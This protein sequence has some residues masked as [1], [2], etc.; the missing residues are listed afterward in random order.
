MF[1]NWLKRRV[2][3]ASVRSATQDLERF[4]ASLRGM[5]DLELATLVVIATAVR[6]SLRMNGQAP[7]EAYGLTNFPP[8][9]QATVQLTVST[10]VRKFQTTER[11]AYASGAMV[12]LHTLRAG[13]MPELSLL[14]RQMWGELSR[15]FPHVAE[16]IED[17]VASTGNA[18]PPEVAQ[19]S[20]FVPPG[21]EPAERKSGADELSAMATAAMTD[22]KAKWIQFNS[23]IHLKAGI[24]LAVKMESFAEPTAAF[25]GKKYP[26]LMSGP[27]EM[28]WLMIFTAVL[29]TGTHAKDEVNAAIGELKRKFGPK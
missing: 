5:S 27:A 9:E 12:W 23:T 4:V 11:P 1:S 17:M 18:L 28:F 19:E 24:P 15:G 10:L 6:M 22:V 25:I 2:E 29:E 3:I 21:L 14:C 8:R 16:A 20:L 26:V 7:D 13:S